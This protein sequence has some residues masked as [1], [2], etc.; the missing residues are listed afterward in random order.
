MQITIE[1]LWKG[2]GSILDSHM[3]SS[4]PVKSPG[5]RNA[6]NLPAGSKNKKSSE[7]AK[8]E[9]TKKWYHSDQIEDDE[10]TYKSERNSA[11]QNKSRQLRRKM[12]AMKEKAWVDIRTVLT[13]KQK[14][15]LANQ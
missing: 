6:G 11:L 4:R 3:H 15:V 2:V 10:P 8:A 9:E 13:D 14:G 1:Q 5:K 12:K 7:K